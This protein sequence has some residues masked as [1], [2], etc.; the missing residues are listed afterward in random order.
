MKTKLTS[1]TSIL[2]TGLAILCFT[3]FRAQ[4]AF[5]P[6]YVSVS[7]LQSVENVNF[8]EWLKVE[9]EYFNKVTKNNNLIIAQEVLVDYFSPSFNEI[10]LIT[11]YKNW[12]D[13]ENVIQVTDDLIEQNWPN[14]TER[15]SFFKKQNSFY[16]NLH[17]D[18]IFLTTKY[19]KEMS[20]EL[21]K[22][23]KPRVFFAQNTILADID[24][25]ESYEIY[26]Q[27]IENV[28]YKN[29]YIEAYE[30]FRY[31]WGADSRMFT[32]IFIVETL[33]DLEKGLEANKDLLKTYLPDETKREEFI[34]SFHKSISKQ[35]NNIYKNVPSL[36]K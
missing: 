23:I 10:K 24:D 30:P 29:Q 17:S 27:Y 25:E 36:S 28:V 12:E 9:E 16:T 11:Y 33:S 14:K 19:K 26:Q 1:I 34:N 20:A 8:K 6:I 35:T 2:F 3:N 13:M 7:T 21:K 15:N 4:N 31:Y 32:E 5:E 22:S 18:N